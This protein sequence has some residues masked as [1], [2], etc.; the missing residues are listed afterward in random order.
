MASFVAS[1]TDAPSLDSAGAFETLHSR[2]EQARASNPRALVTRT[3]LMAGKPVRISI[4]GHA[5]AN[6]FAR[7]FAHLEAAD[8]A[9]PAL[10]I[11][12]WDGRATGLPY[13]LPLRPTE[14]HLHQLSDGE[15]LWSDPSARFVWAE[16]TDAVTWFDRKT[17]QMI[18][19]RADG[20]H[21]PTH[22]RSKPLS[23]LLSLW[24][25]AYDLHVLH[26]GVVTRGGRGIVVTGGSG[27]GKT[28]TTL[29]AVRAGFDFLGDDQVAM[30]QRQDGHL[31][32][33]SLFSS[34]RLEPNHLKNFPEL[35]PHALPS[36][37]PLDNKSLIFLGD[38]FPDQIAQ[39]AEISALVL[40]RLGTHSQTFL[41]PAKRI[42]AVHYMALTS[43]AT[44]FGIG[45]QRFELVSQLLGAVP[46]YWLELGRDLSSIAPALANVS[47][48]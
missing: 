38:V 23:F 25:Y 43:L 30:E 42:E 34:V 8:G 15:F 18:G 22:E 6:V 45:R 1:Q 44:P 10:T 20:Q 19:W 39:S 35:Q 37:D 7:A 24:L 14:N 21:P 16:K 26:A 2:F 5:L 11:E 40:P 32:A 31:R 46:V 48:R 33:H 27:I 9:A 12:L 29:C 13:P 28:T 3:W 41:T 47:Q 17:N 36:I 4:V